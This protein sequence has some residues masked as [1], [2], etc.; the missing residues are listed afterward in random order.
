MVVSQDELKLH[1]SVSQWLSMTIY[2]MFQFVQQYIRSTHLILAKRVESSG[3]RP[4]T[5][6]AIHTPKIVCHFRLTAEGAYY[7]TK[8][9]GPQLSLKLGLDRSRL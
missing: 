4:T 6:L 1:Y 5:A 2:V 9:R 7:R 3:P 8:L